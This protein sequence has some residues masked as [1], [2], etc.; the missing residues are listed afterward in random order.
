MRPKR[1]YR[2]RGETEVEVLEELV[3]R[4]REGMTVLELRARVDADIDTL[5]A[6][7][8]D[9]KDDDLIE[10]EQEGD[11]TLLRPADRVVADG[12]PEPERSLLDRLRDRLPF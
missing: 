12:D 11:R 2:R 8:T 5:E 7:L 10:V 4:R 1:R 3:D 6:T 9:L